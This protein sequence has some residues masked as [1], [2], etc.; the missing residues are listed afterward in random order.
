MKLLG[1]WQSSNH[2]PH[3]LE[4]SLQNKDLISGMLAAG[5]LQMLLFV[6]VLSIINQSLKG[7]FFL[8]A[9]KCM[10]FVKQLPKWS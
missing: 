7:N 2:S 1:D 9:D 4:K 5:L 3:L 8:I 6:D 10:V